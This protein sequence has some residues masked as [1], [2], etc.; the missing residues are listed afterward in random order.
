METL[1]IPADS[2]K[3]I[4][5]LRIENSETVRELQVNQ[6]ALSSILKLVLKGFNLCHLQYI[7]LSFNSLSTGDC[8]YPYNGNHVSSNIKQYKKLFKSLSL[9]SMCL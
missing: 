6:F 2:L 5:T 7:D 1:S 3:Q 8:R 9:Q 4:T